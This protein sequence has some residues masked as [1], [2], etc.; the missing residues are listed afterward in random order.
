MFYRTFPPCWHF[1]IQSFI[2]E[3]DFCLFLQL[4]RPGDAGPGSCRAAVSGSGE[5]LTLAEQRQS[6]ST[7]VLREEGHTAELSGSLSAELAATVQA[8]PR[9]RLLSQGSP[10]SDLESLGKVYPLSRPHP[11]PRV[12]EAVMS[13]NLLIPSEL[14]SKGL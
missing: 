12:L 4:R 6:V 3:L 14:N 2:C 7:P 13:W 1:Q 11:L 10:P 5:R 8:A 9:P